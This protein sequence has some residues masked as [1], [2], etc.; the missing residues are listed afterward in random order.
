MVKSYFSVLFFSLCSNL[1]IWPGRQF[2]P[3]GSR[4]YIPIFDGLV[5]FDTHLLF[6]DIGKGHFGDGLMSNGWL[7]KLAKL[8]LS[9]QET[10][11][12]GALA[13]R[14]DIHSN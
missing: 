1:S 7:D 3:D 4:C 5:Y 11:N 12:G 13:Q 14:T 9:E 6:F 2:V 8:G 10:F